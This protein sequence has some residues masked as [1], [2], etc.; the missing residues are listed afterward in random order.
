MRNSGVFLMAKT[1]NWLIGLLSPQSD[2]N[3][4]EFKISFLSRHRLEQ[5]RSM[6]SNEDSPPSPE[7]SHPTNGDPFYDRFPWFRLIGRAYVY[8]SNLFY[9]VPLVHKVP[10]VSEHG[11][12]KGYLQVAVQA[13]TDD[14]DSNTA[15]KSCG[16]V[17]FDESGEVA[18]ENSNCVVEERLML[19]PHLQLGNEFTFRVTIRKGYNVET[20][21]ADVFCQFR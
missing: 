6:Y 19:P 21:Y 7:S 3:T 9:P 8:L 17:Q 11:D 15:P 10:I 2:F 20:D 4:Q 1:K 14:C 12:V 18:G 13:V 16:R 5:M